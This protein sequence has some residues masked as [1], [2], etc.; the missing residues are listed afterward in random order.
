MP[1]AKRTAVAA[2][3]KPHRIVATLSFVRET[4]GYYIYSDPSG[5]TMTGSVYIS[6]AKLESPA[7]TI[8]V[9][10]TAVI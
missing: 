2:T 1:T 4:K 8:S 7:P 3:P 9:T 5:Q 10:I 6:R